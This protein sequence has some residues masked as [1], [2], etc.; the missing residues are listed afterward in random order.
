MRVEAHQPATLTLPSLE[1]GHPQR[2]LVWK[3][4]GRRDP[5]IPLRAPATEID[6]RGFLKS[7]LHTRPAHDGS[8]LLRMRKLGEPA[9][10]GKGWFRLDWLP[11]NEEH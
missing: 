4:G 3:E 9:P 5:G 6:I 7:F 8:S 1:R 10:R 2:A 11:F